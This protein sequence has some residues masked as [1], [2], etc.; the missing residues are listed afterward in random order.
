[1]PF[2]A[3]LYYQLSQEG[4]FGLPVVLIHGAGGHHLYWP[5]EI[6]RLPGYRIYAPDLPGHGKSSGRGLQTIDLYVRALAE[7]LDSIGIGR[8]VFV[9]HSMGGA[10]ALTIALQQRERVIGLGLVATGAKLRVAPDL[11]NEVSAETTF[12][13]AIEKIAARSFSSQAPERVVELALTRMQEIR[14]SVLHADLRACDG[15]DVSSRVGKIQAPTLVICGEEDR[16]A[17]LRYSQYLADQIEGATLT[18]IP[19][20]GHMVMLEKPFEVEAALVDFFSHLRN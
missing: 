10:I 20:A 19:N 18:V 5:S 2:D 6:R 3:G 4:E 9:G 14:P 11:L 8:A 16:M 1:M 17:P 7:W 13:K 15:F 12:N